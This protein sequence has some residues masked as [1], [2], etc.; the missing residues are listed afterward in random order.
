ME[1]DASMDDAGF[2]LEFPFDEGFVIDIDE[3]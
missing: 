2:D 3:D 1:V